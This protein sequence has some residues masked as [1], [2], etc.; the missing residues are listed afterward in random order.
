MVVVSD[1]CAWMKVDLCPPMDPVFRCSSRIRVS[2]L[3]CQG[4]QVNRVGFGHHSQGMFGLKYCF[5]RRWQSG[6]HLHL[7]GCQWPRGLHRRASLFA[8]LTTVRIC[9]QCEEGVL[10]RYKRESNSSWHRR[11]ELTSEILQIHRE[12][13]AFYRQVGNCFVTYAKSCFSW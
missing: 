9:K 12:H 8:T 2:E 5:R 10:L 6:C 11:L 13:P 1:T 4:I 3:D 7:A